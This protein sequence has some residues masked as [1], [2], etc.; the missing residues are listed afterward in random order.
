MRANDSKSNGIGSVLLGMTALVLAGMIGTIG[1]LQK[2]GELGPKVGDIVSF[3]PRENFSRD[4]KA[5]VTAIPVGARPGIACILDVRTMHASGGSIVIES[6]Q[7]EI[8]A[9][10]RVHWA[11]GN[12]S[13]DGN[14][15]GKSADLLLSREDLEVL[16]IAAGGFGAATRNL[17]NSTLRTSAAASQ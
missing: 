2:V 16:A 6:R 3:D 1:L 9:G 10:F 8:P 11:G 15:C 5:Q 12:S 13:T 4:M 17:T 7:P 14:D